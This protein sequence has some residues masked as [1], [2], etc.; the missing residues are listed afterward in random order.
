M[1][2]KV[3]F[4]PFWREEKNTCYFC[5]KTRSVKYIVDLC[6]VFGGKVLTVDVC[7]RCVLLLNNK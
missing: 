1:N 3:K 4:N 7:N 6:D 5:N 2:H